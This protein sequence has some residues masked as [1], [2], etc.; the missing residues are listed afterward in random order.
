MH[1]IAVLDYVVLA[2]YAHFAG[3][4]D[5]SFCAVL[6]KVFVLDYFRSDE[7][8]FEVGVDYAGGAGSLIPCNYGPSAAF[9]GTCCEEGPEACPCKN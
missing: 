4:T 3:G 6:Y 7:A 9:I 5:C 1:Y 8:A 2:F